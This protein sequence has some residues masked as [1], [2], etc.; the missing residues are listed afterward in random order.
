[1]KATLGILL[2]ATLSLQAQSG[3]H[4]FTLANGL[5][6]LHLEEREHP[7]VRV[8]LFVRL[9]PGDVPPGRQGLPLL[10]Q[11]TFTKGETADLKAG[12]LD[13]NLDD[14]GIQLTQSLEAG[15]VTWRLVTRSRDQDR[16]MGL[17]ADRLLRTLL[18]P[19]LLEAERLVC[20]RLLERPEGT[21]HE[22]LRQ[23][24]AQ[25]PA[26]RPSMSSLGAITLQD[27]LAFRARVLRPDRAILILHG[28][29]GL[30]QAK[31]LVLLSLGAWSVPSPTTPAS[32]APS[33]VSTTASPGSVGTLQIPSPGAGIR[34]QAVA[35]PSGKLPREIVELLGL[36]V[37]GDASLPPVR[38][39]VEDGCLV[40]TLD[41]ETGTPASVAWSLLHDRLEAL[42]QRGFTQADLER[43]RVAWLARRSLDSL[44]VEAQIYGA[45]AEALGQSATEDRMRALSLEALNAGLSQWLD[46]AKLRV[47]ALGEPELLKTLPIR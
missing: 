33:L 32:P 13:R 3:V 25:D 24:L 34:I 40:A 47:G 15:G 10:F 46:P 29:L 30:E 42:R 27:L 2:A 16:A 7:L 19:T 43:A 12:E 28:D 39:G 20:K 9:E 26:A 11:R 1:M 14:S 23:A 21:P 45:L 36:L 41:G 35:S 5:R 38:V 6:V 37:P 8:R 18:D 17:L 4:S 22:R 31:R 44:H